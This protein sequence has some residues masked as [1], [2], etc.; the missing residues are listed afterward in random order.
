[1][2]RTVVVENTLNKIKS[3]LGHVRYLMSRAK[4]TARAKSTYPRQISTRAPDIIK[5]QIQA[6]TRL[7]GYVFF[8]VRVLTTS[9]TH[10]YTDIAM[11]DIDVRL[12][13]PSLHRLV[14]AAMYLSQ[15]KSTHLHTHPANVPYPAIHT[16][17]FLWT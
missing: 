3:L 2:P 12:V 8:H 10:R 11:P 1:M 17:H 7:M 15:A 9:S 14:I 16:A 6:D 13:P 5:V 4:S